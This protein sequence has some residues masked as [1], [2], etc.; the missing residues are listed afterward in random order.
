MI[1]ASYNIY[2][3]FLF[4]NMK[5]IDGYDLDLIF[6]STSSQVLNFLKDLLEV[7]LKVLQYPQNGLSETN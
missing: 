7:F 1:L 6:N 5:F 3:F 2:I 4:C